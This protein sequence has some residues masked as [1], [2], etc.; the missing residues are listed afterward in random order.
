VRGV[1]DYDLTTSA[2]AADEI[3]DGI[4]GTSSYYSRKGKTIAVGQE[5]NVIIPL[6]SIVG[7]LAMKALP[8]S[9]L[10]DTV[11]VEITLA[12]QNAWGVYPSAPATGTLIVKN[13]KLHTSMVRVDGRVE[14][15]MI[16][17]LPQ[18]IAYVPSLD[19]A[20]FHTT[21]GLNDGGISYQIPIRASNISYV[22]IALRP[23]ANL[24]SA[25]AA[26]VTARAKAGMSS[27]RF[28]I[29]TQN[30]PQSDVVCTGSAAEAR[31][32]LHRCFGGITEAASRS[33]ISSV[34]FVEDVA[35]GFC[36]GL[37]MSAF[38]QTDALS[39]GVSTTNQFITFECN[40]G[41]SAALRLDCWVQHEKLLE[42]SNGVMTHRV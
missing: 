1:A 14:R 31:M 8:L 9:M 29:G 12:N 4:D 28:R 36:V 27:Y 25:T 19:F 26:S 39:D 42:I 7:S 38:P 11:R 3:V 32:E 5:L 22:L 35:G 6:V 33:C 30:M 15:A 17:S 18:G 16:K 21:I 37:N 13:V 2:Y 10:I 24:N 20:H 34:E 41:N 23:Q 40:L